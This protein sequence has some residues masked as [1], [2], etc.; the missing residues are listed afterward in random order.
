MAADAQVDNNAMSLD[1]R[2][3]EQDPKVLFLSATGHA[4]SRASPSR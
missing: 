4:A 1:V 2:L 3:H